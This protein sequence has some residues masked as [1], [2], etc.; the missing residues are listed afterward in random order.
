MQ[1]NE[2]PT[3]FDK[4]RK[5]QPE[6]S[7]ENRRRF[8]G[9]SEENRRHATL[10]GKVAIKFRRSFGGEPENRRIIGGKP[11]EFKQILRKSKKHQIC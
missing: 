5:Q 9:D 11:V 4:T 3:Y 10:P 8:G 7:E 2:N 6:E 1:K